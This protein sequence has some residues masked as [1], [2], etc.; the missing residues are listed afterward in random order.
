MSRGPQL[1]D[2]TMRHC[3]LL[4][5]GATLW[6]FWSNAGDAPERIYAA[7][8]DTSAD[9]REWQAG[10]P[11][12]VLRPV[13]DWEGAHLPITPSVR[14]YAPQP[15]HELRDPAVFAEDGQAWLLYTVQGERGIALARL[16]PS[17]A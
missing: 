5:R 14:G 11:R 10:A 16:D 15:V 9:W 7:P 4:R 3:A 2:N 13:Y 8:I 12:D 17:A 1:F 6:V